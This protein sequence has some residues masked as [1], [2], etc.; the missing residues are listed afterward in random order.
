MVEAHAAQEAAAQAVNGV[1]SSPEKAIALHD[2]VRESV[3]FGI[4][5]IDCMGCGPR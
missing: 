5:Q 4:K 1:V 2:D 3:E